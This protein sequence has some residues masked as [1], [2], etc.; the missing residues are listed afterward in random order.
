MKRHAS[1][2]Y[3]GRTLV[4]SKSWPQDAL[5]PRVSGFARD[6]GGEKRGITGRR[7]GGEMRIFLIIFSPPRL[8]VSL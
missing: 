5:V 4:I 6:L 2:Y 8:P 1:P 7:G 3:V